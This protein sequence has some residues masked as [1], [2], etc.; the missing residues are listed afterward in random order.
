LLPL[1]FVG[2][3]TTASTTIARL[4]S[5]PSPSHRLRRRAP[6]PSGFVQIPISHETPASGRLRV[7]GRDQRSLAPLS[8]GLQFPAFGPQ[9]SRFVRSEPGD[10]AQT[11]ARRGLHS[12][13]T[14]ALAILRGIAQASRT[15]A[16]TMSR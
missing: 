13:R 3:M 15:H 9:G 7:G 11:R 2:A 14:A 12:S 1:R 8:L 10:Q 6:W 16:H 5:I 4:R